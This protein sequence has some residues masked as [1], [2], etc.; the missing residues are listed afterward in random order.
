MANP[1]L[2]G[3]APPNRNSLAIGGLGIGKLT[4]VAMNITQQHPNIAAVGCSPG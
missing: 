4:G 2:A 3:V 1:L